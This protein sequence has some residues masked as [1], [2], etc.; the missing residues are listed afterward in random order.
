MLQTSRPRSRSGYRVDN[1]GGEFDGFA[2][3]IRFLKDSVA[4]RAN[5]S[6]CGEVPGEP[7]VILFLG[8]CLHGFG[9]VEQFLGQVIIQFLRLSLPEIRYPR[10]EISE[11][12]GQSLD[13]AFLLARNG[14]AVQPQGERFP[15]KVREVF[16][17][18]FITSLTDSGSKSKENRT[19]TG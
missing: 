8:V 11:F 5:V 4:L 12:F 19:L 14:L 13:V 2:G 15:V 6:R 16:S 10:N 18:S 9:E 3:G 7:V 17:R 1:E